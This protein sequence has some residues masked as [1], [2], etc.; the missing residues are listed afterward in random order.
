MSV[1]RGVFWGLGAAAALLL[2]GA[3]VGSRLEEVLRAG[4]A[5]SWGWFW[6]A[7]AG[8]LASHAMV[9]LALS[10]VL[11]ILGHPLGGPTVL[12]IALVSTTANYL[13]S[14]GGVTGFALKSHLLHK[15][16]VPIATTVTASAVTSAILYAVLAVI[17][18][19]G[20]FTLL[21]R[22][23]GARLAI[24]ES[25]F[26]LIILLAGAAFLLVAFF[27]RS[28][29]GR[30]A[31]RL[32]RFTNRAAFKL[33]QKEI[34][35]EDFAAFEVQ[36]TQGLAHIR[37]GK[38]RL[39]TTVLYTCLDW[40][41]AMTSLWFC[42]RAV[43][44]R[45]PVGHLSAAFTTGQAATLIPVLPG[46]LGAAEGSIAALMGGLG[47][48]AGSALVAALLFRLC[49]Y[50]APALL[51]VLVLWGLKVSEPEVL[52]EAAELDLERRRF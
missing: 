40:G 41:L 34:P 28:V 17:L 45:L 44:V 25:A 48:D 11:T 15:R 12:G 43:G 33:S 1:R 14:A 39:T 9:G 30:L 49:Y 2:L 20:L 23:R 16:R 22:L 26:G 18:G 36:L 38:G 46:G 21:L 3:L 19:Q 24:M 51:S 32:F 31:H 52:Q 4:E 7:L 42:F 47:V 29:R 5:V 6:A 13:V 8:A 35:S 50:V 37:A 10:E 27:N